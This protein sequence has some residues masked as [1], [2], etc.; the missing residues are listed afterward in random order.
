[1]LSDNHNFELPRGDSGLGLFK[2][3]HVALAVDLPKVEMVEIK[4]GRQG[5]VSAHGF[6]G[7]IRRDTG[8]GLRI[9]TVERFHVVRAS[10]L[11]G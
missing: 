3:N 2:Q 8:H 6:E 7:L 10:A 4:F 11:E 9:F 1:M 5:C